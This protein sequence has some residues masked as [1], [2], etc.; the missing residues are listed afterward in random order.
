LSE[1]NQRFGRYGLDKLGYLA[2]GFDKIYPKEHK[3]YIGDIERKGGFVIDFT[4]SE[5]FDRNNFLRRNR[6]IAGLAHAIVVIQSNIIGGSM[7]TADYAHQH[8]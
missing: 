3:K 4:S 5:V 2:H 1:I 7:N 8:N 6:I